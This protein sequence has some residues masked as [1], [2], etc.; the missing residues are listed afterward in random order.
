MFNQEKIRPYELSLWTLQD[1]FISTL[2]SEDIFNKGQIE[3]PRLNIRNDGTL[4]LNFLIPMY[5]FEEGKK[6]ENPIW[7]NV[8]DK[9]LIVNLRKLKLIFN[10][11]K[12]EEEIFEFVINKIRE[13]H[14]DGKLYCE[15]TAEGLAFQELGK[16][17]YKISLSSEDFIEEYNNWYNST[18]GINTENEKFDYPTDEDKAAA[19]PKNNI[20]Y[21]C[22][23]ILKNSNWSYSIQMDWSSYDGILI[24]GEVNNEERE[25]ENLRRTDKI[26]EEEYI[27]SWEYTNTGTSSSEVLLPSKMESF[28]EKLRLVDLEKSNIYN[29][30]QN[31]L[32]LLEFFVNIN[33]IMIKNIIL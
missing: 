22:D 30:T 2:K 19:E 7:Y 20:N 23:K 25:K 27:S 32:K 15:V 24:N 29:L 5:Y 16:V 18:V 10:K 21:W 13:E 9:T 3:T 6:I 11:G 14:A 1:D 28:K 4:E 31:L 8:I 33:I 17:G 26:Y 12:S